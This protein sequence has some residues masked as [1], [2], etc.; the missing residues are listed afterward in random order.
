MKQVKSIG[1]LSTVRTGEGPSG[2]THQINRVPEGL[3]II[4]EERT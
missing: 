4:T 2:V 1:I 3:G